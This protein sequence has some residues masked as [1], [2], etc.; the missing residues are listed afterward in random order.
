M[1]EIYIV[2]CE[3]YTTLNL[4]WC[5]NSEKKIFFLKKSANINM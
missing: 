5:I 4:F 2:Y 1:D 3:N